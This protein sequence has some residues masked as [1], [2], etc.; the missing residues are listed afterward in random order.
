M[1][2]WNQFVFGL[3][4]F[5]ALNA[6]PT[7]AFGA[8][9]P[10]KLEGIL[11]FPGLKVCLFGTGGDFSMLLREQQRDGDFEVLKIDAPTGTVRTR[12]QGSSVVFN[13]LNCPSS[14][15]ALQ[16]AAIGSVL[17]LYGQL[18]DR[19][20]LYPE[21]GVKT[22][23]LRAAA[24]DKAEAAQAIESALKKQG[25]TIV[26]DGKKFMLVVPPH[27]AGSAHP[28]ST[29]VKSP[30]AGNSAGAEKLIPRGMMDFRGVG[31]MQVLSIYADLAGREILNREE[32]GRIACGQIAFLS[33]T[34][35]TKADALYAL[36]TLFEWAGFKV[37]K[38]G[39]KGCKVVSVKDPPH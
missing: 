18:L 22:I 21:L 4:C 34:E 28:K 33:E 25:L 3:C 20:I 10:T 7:G 30:A 8:G 1:K 38:L 17:R 23:T 39:E 26:P 29:E 37:V 6:T 2:K 15:I 11:D 35:M 24:Q 27:L 31:A 19:N 9:T 14:G 32:A 13:M 12:S 36:E 16:D 5:V